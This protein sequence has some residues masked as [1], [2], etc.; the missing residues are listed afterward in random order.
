MR[1]QAGIYMIT[2]TFGLVLG[3]HIRTA[4]GMLAA[5]AFG[6]GRSAKTYIR[7]A[8][9]LSAGILSVSEHQRRV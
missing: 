3:V 9:N 2:V 5:L 4:Q 7:S 6:Q 8:S 1:I